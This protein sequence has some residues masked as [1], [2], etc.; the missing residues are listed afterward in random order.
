MLSVVNKVS[1][2]VMEFDTSS[3]E[4]IVEAYRYAQE[5]DKLSKKVKD[6]LKKLVPMLLDEQGRS[7][8]IGDYQF[9][10]YETQRTTYEKSVLRQV[11]DEDTMDLFLKVHKKSVDDY[12]SLHGSE[13]GDDLAVVKAAVIPDG[14]VTKTTRLD[15][16]V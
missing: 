8:I 10:Q 14:N 11:F 12:L 2:E 15:K 3:K 4:A 5:L 13:L 9:K 6:E 16:V 1:G 7:P